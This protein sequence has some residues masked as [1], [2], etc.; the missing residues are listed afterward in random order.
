LIDRACF[1]LIS[2]VSKS[3]TM[4]CGS[5]WRFTAVV[6]ISSNAAFIP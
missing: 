2:A 3:P 1:S 6:M 5:C 4:R